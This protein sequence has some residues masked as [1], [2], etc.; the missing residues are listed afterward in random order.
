[1]VGIPPAPLQCGRRKCVQPAVLHYP[2]FDEQGKRAFA[3]RVS[4]W[5]N[6]CAPWGSD[7]L[8]VRLRRRLD[9][10][11][12]AGSDRAVDP[13]EPAAEM[14]RRGPGVHPKTSAGSGRTNEL[15]AWL[16]A[17]APGD[18]LPSQFSDV[19]HARDWLPLA[20]T[21]MP[22]T[23]TRRPRPCGNG[24]PASTCPGI[25]CPSRSLT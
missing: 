11:D 21:R 7:D 8:P 19:Q 9:T 17:G 20:T 5:I 13:G 22:S 10:S 2:P 6:C 25:A 3:K 12:H 4:A 16:R 18:D 14:C 24:A 1:M 15:A 23:S